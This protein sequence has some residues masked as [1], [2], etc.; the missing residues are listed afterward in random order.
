M[1]QNKCSNVWFVSP[2]SLS[3]V[4]G[5]LKSLL[6]LSWW[7]ESPFH[8]EAVEVRGKSGLTCNFP[9]RISLMNSW[10]SQKLLCHS[11]MKSGKWFPAASH[12]H[13]RGLRDI[14]KR[15]PSI[16]TRSYCDQLR[17]M[18]TFFFALEYWA[19]IHPRKLLSPRL[20]RRSS[21]VASFNDRG[22]KM[23]SSSKL[24]S[25]ASSAL[26]MKRKTSST[27]IVSQAS[28]SLHFSFPFAFRLH[29][30]SISLFLSRLFSLF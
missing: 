18:W 14:V 11:C 12:I 6:K 3:S 26:S 10:T 1:M 15:R 8:N 2:R 9:C 29:N 27:T 17:T 16:R 24:R 28:H 21:S 5:L 7:P 4:V 23:F 25:S 20:F 19:L 13:L 30:S 22:R